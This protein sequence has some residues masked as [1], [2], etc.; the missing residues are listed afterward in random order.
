MNENTNYMQTMFGIQ[1][2][3]SGDYEEDECRINRA[4]DD[5]RLDCRDLNAAQIKSF[6]I[7]LMNE[8]DKR[9]KI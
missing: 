5:L 9:A 2:W 4:I 6:L 8:I 1:D 7:T 3:H